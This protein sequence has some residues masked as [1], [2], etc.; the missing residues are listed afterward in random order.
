MRRTAAARTLTLAL[1]LARS[2]A[3]P[4]D[5][6][7]ATLQLPGGGVSIGRLVA[8][9]RPG[10]VAWQADAFARP[11]AFAAEAV[12]SIQW[13]PSQPPPR[14]SGTFRFELDGGDTLFGELAGLD[15]DAASLDLGPLGRRRV[16]RDAIRRVDRWGDGSTLVYLGPTGLTG[17]TATPGDAW[18]DVSGMPATDRPGASLGASLGLPGRA[19]IDVELSWER[20]ADFTLVLGSGTDD[21]ATR[22]AFR[23]EVWNETLVAVRETETEADLASLGALPAGPG[24]VAFRFYL[25]QEAGTLMVV[26]PDGARLAEL[27]L[28]ARNPLVGDGVT[29]RNVSGDIRLDRLQI[30]HWDGAP[31]Q[32][33]G[34]GGR[35]TRSDGTRL[36]GRVMR[37][38]GGDL[39]VLGG[40]GQETRAAIDHVAGFALEGRAEAPRANARV[41]YQNGSRLSGVLKA[42]SESTITLERPGMEGLVELPR[43]G[44]RSVSLLRRA[45][46]PVEAP[47]GV[48]IE[49]DDG[50]RL[51]GRLVDAAEAPGRSCLA[52]LPDG[53]TESAPLKPGLAG[54]IIFREPPPPAPAA[55]SQEEQLIRL[56]RA[57]AP[58]PL[59]ALDRFRESLAASRAAPSRPSG[60]TLHLRSGDTIPC[61]VT[62]IDEEGVHFTSPMTS[63]TFVPH[64][65]IK[66]LDL[67]PLTPRVRVGKV[68]RERLLTLPR[69]QKGSPPTQ[70][71]RA[72]TG[73]YV[74]GRLVGMD[75]E[76]L[77]VELRLDERAI[78]RKLVAHVIWL[79]PDELDPEA[80]GS[81]AGPAPGATRVQAVRSDGT[82]L[83]FLADR[84]ADGVLS[85]TSD[86]LGPCKVPLAGV[87]RLAFGAAIEQ[88]AAKL[89]A[90]RW[91]L[92]PAPEPKFANATEGGGASGMESSLVGRPAP[93]FELELLDGHKFR[94]ADQKGQV[95]I[96]DFWATWCG[97]CVQ[98][99]PQ[100]ERVAGEFKERGVRL[101]AVNLQETPDEIRA[102]LERHNLSPE[103]ALD[104]D[105]VVAQ[106]YGADAIPQTVIIDRDGKIAR[107]YVGAGPKFDE[108]LRQALEQVLAGGGPAE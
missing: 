105:G 88:E 26:A 15:A 78:D 71:I 7:P 53:G 69:M 46:A 67:A 83:T 62:A 20:R 19:A 16:R 30:A 96:L 85:G 57:Q 22:R 60:P 92:R 76:S 6:A 82:R 56:R 17:W 90:H 29:L 65:K 73:D 59:R 81:A 10:V 104:R 35:V 23:I 107:L 108:T 27:K 37:L 70:L 79:H 97:P 21:R 25:D 1:L 13:S 8:S 49:L 48:R 43:A 44:L 45:A 42:V 52:W 3:A 51:P 95:V 47:P 28:P 55:P 72:R 74:R 24:R 86:V 41:I 89:A 98:A 31:P 91:K 68:K 84:L 99:M 101:V 103:V 58:G 4:A 34:G 9:D 14:P 66:A 39:I 18:R 75:A 77:R 11:F 12:E 100:V 61:E 50:T 106:K 5:D 93:E 54:R 40:D 2:P 80:A 87:D 94:L 64:S 32:P 36:E 63:S 33:A 102:M 38:L